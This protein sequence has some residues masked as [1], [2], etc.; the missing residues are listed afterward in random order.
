MGGARLYKV[1]SP[2]NASELD[3]MDYAQSFDTMYLVHIDH[4]VGKLTRSSHT[5]WL[6]S[7]VTFGPGI[8]S[9]TGVSVTVTNPNTDAANE[10]NAYFPQ[11][12]SYV[13]SAVN[14]DTG[15]ESRASSSASGTNDLGLK[16]NKN[17]ITWTAVDDA[18]FYRIYK[19]NNTG[20]FGFIGEAT[21]TSFVDDNINPDLSDAPIV[22]NNPFASS[23][24]YPS[25]ICFFEQ[26]VFFGRTKNAPNAIYGTRSAD[27]ENMDK[28]RPL[29]ADDSLA[30]AATSGTVNAV[31]QL[32][33]ANNLLALTSDSIFEIVG[34]NDDYIS[35]N[36]PPKVRRQNG[37]GA[38]D[39]KALLIDSVTFFQ[40]NIG[41]QVRTL[42]FSFEINGLQSNDISIFSSHF[43]EDHRIVS[44]CYAEEPLSVIWAV[45]D[46][47]KL[48]AFT[49][50][51]EQQVWGWT[52]CVIDG[53]VTSVCSI[54]ENGEDRVYLI[55]KR[56]IDGADR[57]YVEQMAP[58]KWTDFKE[59][60][61][62]DCS[63][64]YQLDEPASTFTHLE[65]LEGREVW[66]L[67]DGFT[68][69]GLTVAN[70]QVTLPDPASTVVIGLPVIATAETM[71]LLIQSQGGAAIGTKQTTGRAHLRIVNSLGI[72][73]G[74]SDD[75]QEPVITR[76]EEPLGSQADLYTGIVRCE[77]E[78]LV[79][80]E[81]TVVI[82]QANP[83]PMRVT[84]AYLEATGAR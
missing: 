66:A 80:Y 30:I 48:L 57:Y 6:F 42:G 79:A 78:Q 28:A 19:S 34:A 77:M 58:V 50:Q 62:L 14:E 36:P 52:E 5:D 33:P 59:A 49:W 61:Y 82:Q 37:R 45:R 23:G 55:I 4:P 32:I 9:P 31:N 29:K 16:R 21:G 15:Q 38:S 3:A 84:A 69:K 47:G 22:G 27:F 41:T 18:T 54:P 51:N 75:S 64:G 12:A 71:G 44:W 7:D 26:R 13:V 46:D 11:P 17:T 83:L 40:P 56:K 67:A 72:T 39:L 68:V 25:S 24:N 81:S 63:R 60:C 53:E 76:E 74:R 73:A 35:P 1:G 70:G 20:S 8:D 2:Y 43:F 65:H 10:G